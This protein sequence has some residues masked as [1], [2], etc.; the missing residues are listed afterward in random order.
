METDP[1]DKAIRTV[2]FS[3]KKTDWIVWS[4]KFLA[5][6]SLKGYKDVLVGKVKPPKDSEVLDSRQE[7]QTHLPTMR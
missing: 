1:F 7:R 4:E 5:Q 3:G 2:A 6:A